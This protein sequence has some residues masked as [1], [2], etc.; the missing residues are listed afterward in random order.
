M[1]RR[2]PAEGRGGLPGATLSGEEP[3]VGRAH[4]DRGSS[5]EAR[6]RLAGI[7]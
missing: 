6:A 3:P 1:E 2:K 7:P 5:D 4:H